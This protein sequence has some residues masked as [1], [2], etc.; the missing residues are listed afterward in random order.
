MKYY[1]LT[2]I[3]LV[4]FYSCANEDTTAPV[5]SEN[6][7]AVDFSSVTVGAQAITKSS[8]ATYLS[9]GSG[10]KIAAYAGGTGTPVTKTY[11]VSDANGTIT[12]TDNLNMML[13]PVQAYTL[14][15]Y[16]PV[17]DFSTVSTDSIS[18]SQGTD[19]LL[20]NLTATIAKAS[21]ETLTFPS[22]DHKCSC[23]EFDLQSDA[24]NTIIT[25]IAVG[26]N[27]LSLTGLTHSP[28]NCSLSGGFNLATAALDGTGSIA[29]S[30]FTGS[31]N[32]YSGSLVVLP[33]LTG[34]VPM[35]ID[36]YINGI[37]YTVS[38]IIP[39]IIFESGK[40]YVFT[41]D[42]KDTIVYLKLKVV[43]WNAIT[44][45]SGQM[46]NGSGTIILGSWTV[47]SNASGQV[48]NGSGNI[49]VGDWIPV[50]GA[51]GN[52][53]NGS[54]TVNA[55]DWNS[56]SSTAGN[57]GDGSGTVKSVDWTSNGSA[58]GDMGY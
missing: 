54:G 33:K 55:V 14:Y 57:I 53:G 51:L 40:K 45:A 21:T 56:T 15:E 34:T 32:V 38:A 35:A 24:S 12:P 19:L 30:S 16:S 52:M 9:Q 29:Q 41:V 46:G 5:T 31:S 7:C 50:S 49:S 25:S 22:L 3:V 10:V 44:D 8:S 28:L 20:S 4:G 36:C 48:G 13:M 27:G 17:I 58:A 39:S 37:R 43:D 26:S 2:L 6:L 18:I 23:L 1:M 47:T 11:A 42:F